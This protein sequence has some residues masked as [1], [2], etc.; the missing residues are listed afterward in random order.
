M[1]SVGAEGG[2]KKPATSSVAFWC[3]GG[4]GTLYPMSNYFSIQ[5]SKSQSGL[6]IAAKALALKHRRGMGHITYGSANMCGGTM[7]P[8]LAKEQYRW[9][10]MFPYHEASG[11]CAHWTGES[12]LTNGLV[13]PDSDDW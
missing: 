13:S 3:A 9:S 8:F 1:V 6:H 7:F 11:R 4:W 2:Q 12:T 10:Q 5:V